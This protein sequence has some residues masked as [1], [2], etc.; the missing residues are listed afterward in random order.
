MSLLVGIC[1][2]SGSGKTTLANSVVNR[3]RVMNGPMAASVLSFDAYYRNQDHLTPAQRAQVNYDH[4]DSL[5][6]EFLVSHLDQLGKGQEAAVPVYDFANY[7]R[8]P[9]IRIVEP[10]EVIIVEG[11]LLL[12][13]AIV[14]DQLDYRVFRYCPEAVRFERRMRRDRTER[15]RTQASVEAQLRTTV[16]P[17]HDRFVEP[18]ASRA[19]FVT[20]H[21]QRLEAVT[22][23]LVDKLTN[24]AA[25]ST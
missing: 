3:L 21:G 20:H 1:G 5:D 25:I 6:A 12:A 23:D 22:D 10:A 24:I 14:C 16:K 19:D 13:F 11:I 7:T 2:G 18:Y 4:P 15:G 8:S 17:M 9:D